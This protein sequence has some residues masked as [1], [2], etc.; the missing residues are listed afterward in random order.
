MPVPI[1][2]LPVDSGPPLPKP[3]RADVMGPD[4]YMLDIACVESN[5]HSPSD[6][7]PR[8]RSDALDAA[9]VQSSGDLGSS[10]VWTST[11]S[12]GH[13]SSTSRGHNHVDHFEPRPNPARTPTSSITNKWVGYLRQRGSRLSSETE[14]IPEDRS[15]QRRSNAQPLLEDREQQQAKC[16][17]PPPTG[18]QRPSSAPK[19]Q[20]QERN[21]LD[22]RQCNERTSGTTG[23]YEFPSLTPTQPS[24]REDDPQPERRPTSQ[25]QLVAEVKGIYAGLVMVES[26]CIEVDN[27]QSPTANTNANSTLNNEQWQALIAQH[28]ELLHEHHDFFLACQHP[29]PSPA[30]QKLVPKYAMPA[31]MWR[32][33]IH[34]FLE[35]LRHRLPASLE[36]MLT[37]LYLA[38]SIIALLY[39]TVP[40]FEDTW[41]E[42]LGDLGRYRMAIK[43]DDF[44]DR[45]TW[46]GISRDWY[47]KASEASPTTGRLYHRLAILA[48]PNAIRQ[49][50]YYT[51]SIGVAVSLGNATRE[52][53]MTLF[54]PVLAKSPNRL[55]PIDAEFVRVHGTLFSGKS[56]RS[57][58]E[59][60]HGLLEQL[61]LYILRS[62]RRWLRAE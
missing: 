5:G 16:R 40:A 11:I 45:E 34:S 6:D 3:G 47:S 10:R 29:S 24:S 18:S 55:V 44:Q 33:G 37:F 27:A 36:H 41:I 31:R 35:L 22:K 32:H 12:D 53:I 13:G 39:E 20:I 2:C 56:K 30:L 26:K 17:F 50:S 62:T 51:K 8:V 52:S 54:D 38:Y 19:N 58:Q 14:P 21:D 1:Q 57:L 28:T 15:A 43:D 23:R 7:S 4:R 9:D 46:A 59:L 60:C 25:D 42:C 49:L 48:H 61:G